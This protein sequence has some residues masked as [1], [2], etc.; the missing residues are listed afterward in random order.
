MAAPYA[1]VDVVVLGH[2]AP[3]TVVLVVELVEPYTEVV[4]VVDVVDEDADVHDPRCGGLLSPKSVV[5]SCSTAGA[6]TEAPYPDCSK[7]ADTT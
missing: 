2:R 1:L 7:T 3:A 5:Y 6:A 4:E